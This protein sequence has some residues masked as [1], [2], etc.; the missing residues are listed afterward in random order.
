MHGATPTLPPDEDA[1]L[2]A[3]RLVAQRCLYGVDRN[4]FA[5]EL[6]KLS[7]WLATLARD[8]EFTFLDHC[9]RHGDSLVGLNR[10]QLGNLH[11]SKE[12]PD[13]DLLAAQLNDLVDQLVADRLGK[14][15]AERNRIRQAMEELSEEDL[16]P[17]LAR[18]L[19]QLDDPKLIADA[20]VA[21][22]FAGNRPADRSRALREMRRALSEPLQWHEMLE[23][24]VAGLRYAAKPVTP[25]HWW[26]E[27]PEVFDRLNPGFDAVV[28]NPPFMGGTVISEK[29]GMGY[30]DWLITNHTGAGHHCDLVAYFFRGVFL[31]TR[32]RGTFGLVATNTLSQGDT[33]EGGLLQLIRAG[34]VIYS[35]Q[36]RLPWPG[37]AAVVVSVVHVA[38][39]LDVDRKQID[40]K[41]ASRISAYLVNGTIDVSPSR[42]AEN[43]YFSLGSKIYGQGFLFDDNDEEISPIH[44]MES[45]I[46]A[47]PDH[48]LRILSYVG[49]ED[50]NSSPRQISSRY[51]IFLS[52]LKEE[53]ELNDWPILR[54]I[55]Y[56]KVK[57]ERDKLGNNPNNIP[58]KRRWWTYQAHRPELYSQLA[59]LRHCMCLS[60]V[61]QHMAFALSPSNV[62][63]AHTVV[64][65]ALDTHAAFCALQARPHELWARFFGSSM[66]DDLRYTPSDCFETF[67]FP[68]ELRRPTQ[69]SKPP[70]RPT[71]ISAPS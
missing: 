25:F 61:G 15:E 20:V 10:R 1:L 41:Q 58:L 5:A 54:D 42:L 38:K 12:P 13:E 60:Q 2:H 59:N 27:F 71:T 52:D 18:A 23:A 8:H 21:A 9:I 57:P 32:D 24:Y 45:L 40:G 48:L 55:V 37:D 66:K 35:V 62:I 56:S 28:G 14:I 68:P 26:L 22:F 33:R 69:R 65:I 4:A 6:G 63:F 49:G 47:S 7:L 16:R 43:P 30:F 53:D 50:I 34:G 3:R 51:A 70:A 44:V 67:P 46:S 36:R 64:V 39:G 31:L 29:L 19:R 17:I 11:W